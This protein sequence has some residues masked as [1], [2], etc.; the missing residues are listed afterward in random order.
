M[1][2]RL[3]LILS[4]CILQAFSQ[5]ATTILEK[6]DANMSSRNRIFESSM[7]ILG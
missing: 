7:T 3:T 6:V 2:T 1:K 5:D 4:I